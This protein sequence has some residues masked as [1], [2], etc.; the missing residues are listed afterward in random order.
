MTDTRDSLMKSLIHLCILVLTAHL[1]AAP[2][3]PP[4]GSLVMIGGALNP[5]NE[6]IYRR[7]IELGG[8]PRDI[9]IAIIPAASSTPTRTGRSYTKDF[10]HF[11]VRRRQIR[12]FPL[13][14]V[15]DPDTPKVDE[16]QWARNAWDQSLAASMD[17]VTAIF[18]VG[19][20]QM[21]YWIT[22]RDQEGH[23]SVLLKKIKDIYHNGGVIGGTSAGAAIMSDP[24]LIDGT[25]LT[26]LGPTREAEPRVLVKHGMGFFKQGLVDEHFIQRGRLGRLIAALLT[27]EEL[28]LGFGIDEDTA[29]VATGDNLDVIGTSGVCIV[30][31]SAAAHSV[32]ERGISASGIRLHFL[33]GGDSYN[34]K[35]G[36]F[37]VNPI[38]APIQA[39]KEYF[40]TST[41]DTNI[42]AKDTVYTL[43][44]QGLIDNSADTA[45]GLAFTLDTSG[46]GTGTKLVFHQDAQSGAYWGKVNGKETYTALGISL[47]IIPIRVTIQ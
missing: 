33:A 22:L 30:D 6:V 12:I 44:T 40:K 32:T 31:V 43:I 37:T 1:A 11:G 26:A 19:G 24:M 46:C 14:L 5:R 47:D 23:D 15:D 39:G 16:S 9:Q 41:L 42:F 2:Q 38:R 4:C 17:N 8:G 18:F 20:D 45:T 21:R 34:L 28:D 13:A 3:Q 25:S 27:N 36:T 10:I 35:T 7:F 29:L